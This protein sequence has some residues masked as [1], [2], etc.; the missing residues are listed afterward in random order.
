MAYKIEYGPGGMEKRP[1]KPPKRRLTGVTAG[2]FCLFLL[3]TL[4]FWPKGRTAL[5]DI[6]L[7]G[8]PEVTAEA[9]RDL[10]SDLREGEG[11]SDAVTA[12]CHQIIE[13]S[14]R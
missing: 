4:L 11:L 10:T 2:A 5:R 8:D 13:E 1:V 14:G 9:L 3:L 6:V 7:P 12:F